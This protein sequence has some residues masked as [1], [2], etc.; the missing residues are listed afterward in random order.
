MSK[1]KQ[2]STA[3]RKR[4]EKKQREEQ[5]AKKKATKAAAG[6]G[7]DD[8]LVEF[9]LGREQVV[10][11]HAA[12]TDLEKRLGQGSM[13]GWTPADLQGPHGLAAFAR[14]LGEAMQGDDDPVQVEV[15]EQAKGPLLDKLSALELAAS[16][17]KVAWDEAGF[18]QLVRAL[19]Q[20]T[21][22]EEE[23]EEEEEAAADEKS[24]DETDDAAASS[25]DAAPAED[26]P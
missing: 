8:V 21:E 23:D 11:C 4:I 5:R 9:T 17:L 14:A 24:S 10:A 3:I 22:V 2:R 20:A 19:N 26:T 12:L 6:Q 7:G 1:R 18:D 25:S 16:G 15:L 13:R